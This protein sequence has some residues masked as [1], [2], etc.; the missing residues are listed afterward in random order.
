MSDDRPN[1]DAPTDTHL[2]DLATLFLTALEVR[3]RGDVDRAIELLNKVLKGEPRLAE[4]RLELGRIQLEMGKLD[5]AEAQTREAL[6]VLLA[7]GHWV[8]DVPE[9]VMLSLAHNQL[10][11]LLRRRAE[12]DEVVFGDPEVFKALLKEA[13]LHFDKAGKLD[14]DND[15]AGF[16]AFHMPG[17]NPEDIEP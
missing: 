15:H 9:N 3:R 11:E 10:A 5:E 17:E 12:S 6:R 16:F 13:Q 14:P 2:E 1:T 4:P 8:E 7:G